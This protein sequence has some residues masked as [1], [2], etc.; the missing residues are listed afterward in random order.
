MED[1]KI[2]ISEDQKLKLLGELLSNESSRKIMKF[3]TTQESYT[4]NIA[5]SLDIRVNLVIHHLKKM[6]ELGILIITN[7]KIIKKGKEHKFF[8]INPKISLLLDLD[9][10]KVQKN[11]FLKKYLQML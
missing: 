1:I 9:K 2:F 11:N 3:L 6:D 8:K 10:D 4:N 5:T 7:K